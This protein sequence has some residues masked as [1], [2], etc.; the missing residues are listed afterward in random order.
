MWGLVL[1]LEEKRFVIGI[2]DSELR[3][4]DIVYLEEVVIVFLLWVVLC[5]SSFMGLLSLELDVIIE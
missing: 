1:V 3:V 5:F 2:F 4:W